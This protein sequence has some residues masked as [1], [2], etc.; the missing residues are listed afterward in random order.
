[1]I[2]H[3]GCVLRSGTQTPWVGRVKYHI[4]LNFSNT[5]KDNDCH[6]TSPVLK[7][8]RI[9]QEPSLTSGKESRLITGL[10]CPSLDIVDIVEIPQGP[11]R[12]GSSGAGPLVATL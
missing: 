1:M 7:K 4:S 10:S 12:A 6:T 8:T 5:F 3:V 9:C 11:G 2:R